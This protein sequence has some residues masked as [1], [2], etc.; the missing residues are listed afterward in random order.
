MEVFKK[1]E[2]RLYVFGCSGHK[3]RI[4]I[5]EVFK[6]KYFLLFKF[7]FFKLKISSKFQIINDSQN[8]MKSSMSD[9]PNT[10]YYELYSLW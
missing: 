10:S 2:I 5:S 1:L 9:C 4:F 7:N 3:F 8:F 6:K